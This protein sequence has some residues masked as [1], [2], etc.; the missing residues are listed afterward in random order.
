MKGSDLQDS[1]NGAARS[2]AMNTNNAH[3][4]LNELELAEIATES[5][6]E[7]WEFQI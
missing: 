5:E 2:L 7:N 1:V 6:L 3:N 4:P